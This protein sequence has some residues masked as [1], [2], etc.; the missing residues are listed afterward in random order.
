MNADQIIVM[1]RG[2]VLESGTHEE[3]LALGGVYR[4]IYDI[5]TEGG[6]YDA[7]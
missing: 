2:R 4:K 3:L 1:D 5:Q 6:D 7:E